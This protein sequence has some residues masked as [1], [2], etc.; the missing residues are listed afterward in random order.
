[1]I[2]FLDYE[3]HYPTLTSFLRDSRAYEGKLMMIEGRI[4]E[5]GGNH[6]VVSTSNIPVRIVY[7]QSEFEDLRSP[8]VAVLGELTGDGGIKVFE[9]H[10]EKFLTIRYYV[11]F[12][13]FIMFLFFFFKEWKLTLRGFSERGGDRA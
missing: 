5:R 9:V 8:A 1:M 7:E 2:I 13:V 11:S 6:Y 10:H 3:D 4:I 12:I